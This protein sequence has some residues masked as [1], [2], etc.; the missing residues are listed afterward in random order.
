MMYSEF[1]WK[2]VF[3]IILARGSFP[4]PCKD[5]IWFKLTGMGEGAG[6]GGVIV[7]VFVDIETC[8]YLGSI[9]NF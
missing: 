1:S 8:Q 5:V 6:C 2:M 9:T 7:P 4:V 3:G